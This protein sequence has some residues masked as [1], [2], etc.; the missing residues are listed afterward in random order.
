[1]SGFHDARGPLLVAKRR[2]RFQKVAGGACQNRTLVVRSCCDYYILEVF[3]FSL[4]PRPSPLIPHPSSLI[5]HPS[6]LI[7]RPSSLAPHPSPLIPH[8]SSLIPHPSS[9]IPHPSS[10]APHPSPPP[11]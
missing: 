1:M 5:P 3:R 10:L 11:T 2:S 7:P 6:P 4:I 8:P 9:L